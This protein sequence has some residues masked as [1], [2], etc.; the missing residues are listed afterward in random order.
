MRGNL[1]IVWFVISFVVATVV[2][3][4]ESGRYVSR[5]IRFVASWG[6]CSATW[7]AL[8]VGSLDGAGISGPIAVAF[9]AM[10]SAVGCLVAIDLFV[11]RLPLLISEGSF[12]ALLPLLVVGD[13]AR[14]QRIHVVA[15]ALGM[16]AIVAVAAASSR[17]IGRGDVHLAPL[18]GLAVGWSDPWRIPMALLFAVVS[19]G[20]VSAVLLA[21]RRVQRD[22]TIAY[23]PFLVLG[24]GLAIAL[25]R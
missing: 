15:G 14:T 19:G 7:I 5:S 22:S 16:F 24:S 10:S 9:G 13:P 23:G 25:A 21:S 1:P 3:V 4:F 6:G 17:A 8:T 11:K 2:L 18:L 12:I 20:V